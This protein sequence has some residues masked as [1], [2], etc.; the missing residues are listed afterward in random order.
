ML[1]TEKYPLDVYRLQAHC[2]AKRFKCRCFEITDGAEPRI[3]DETVETSM[4]SI[5]LGHNSLP[6]SLLRDIERMLA[7][8]SSGKIGADCYAARVLDGS[9]D[10]APQR[11]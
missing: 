10:C 4:G 11:A 8:I 3:V 7:A 9:C 5:D 1:A 6:I 2:A